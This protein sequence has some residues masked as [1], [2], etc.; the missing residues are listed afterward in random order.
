MKYLKGFN[1]AKSEKYKE[2]KEKKSK[3]N[4]ERH[5]LWQEIKSLQKKFNDI[6]SEIK[7]IEDE[8]KSKKVN[9]AKSDKYVKLKSKRT[10]MMEDIEVN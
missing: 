2:L 8:M 7:D 9:E 3:L 1:E 5:K 4:G 6:G 10:E